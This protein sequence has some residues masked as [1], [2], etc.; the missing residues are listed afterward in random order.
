M[1]V[2]GYW[3][4]CCI[5]EQDTLATHS[6]ALSGA[7]PFWFPLFN[8]NPLDFSEC[9]GNPRSRGLHL[10]STAYWDCCVVFCAHNNTKISQYLSQTQ[11]IQTGLHYFA[12][13]GQIFW[14]DSETLERGHRELKFKTRPLNRF[15]LTCSFLQIYCL[16]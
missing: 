4:C 15:S 5:L 14:N 6:T 3:D 11:T 1:N 10:G 8:Q 13:I 16:G 12:E 9:T 7:D 2:R